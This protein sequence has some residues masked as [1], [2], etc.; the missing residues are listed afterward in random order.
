M[1]AQ[2]V[3]SA[4][5]RILDRHYSSDRLCKNQYDGTFSWDCYGRGESKRAV[6]KLIGS[7]LLTLHPVGTGGVTSLSKAG[8]ALVS[9]R[10]RGHLPPPDIGEAR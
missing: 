7:G 10:E 6:E 5:Q 3:T 1:A 4:G 2:S 9:K 8:R